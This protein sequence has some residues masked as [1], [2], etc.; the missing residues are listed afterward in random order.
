MESAFAA[1][2]RAMDDPLRPTPQTLLAAWRARVGADRE[3][4]ARLREAPDGQDFYGPVAEAFRADPRRTGE[5]ALDQLLA[6]V[7]PGETWLDIGAGGGRYALPLALKAGRVI[8]LDPSPGMLGVLRSG[9]S[10]HGIDNIDI[11]ESRWPVTTGAAPQADVAMIAHVGY[12]IEDIGPFIEA[13]E[14]SARRLCVAVLLDRPP[15]S[16]YFPLFEAAHGEPRIPLP[17]LRE[18]LQ[19][20]LA[21]ER[22]FELSLSPRTPMAFGAAREDALRMARRQSWTVAGSE[23]DTRMVA[24][25]DRL[26]VERDGRITLSGPPVTVAVVR[27]AP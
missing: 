21:R 18:F 15:A 14:A 6:L 8:A 9:M 27:W 13:M 10:G 17:A 12:D 23:K 24:A 19:L 7:E 4:V 1:K 26:L 16:P 22:L 3:Q 5:P 25:L 11:V 2:L 20:L